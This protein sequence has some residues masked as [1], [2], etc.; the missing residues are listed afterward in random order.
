MK[1][2]AGRPKIIVDWKTVGKY[3]QAQC[4][5]TGIAGLLGISVDTLYKACK[6]DNKINFTVF[7]E[8]KKAEGKELLRVKQFQTAMTGNVPMCI[9]LGKQYLS[10]SDKQE[11]TGKDGKDLIPQPDLSKLTDDELRTL[12]ELQ[13]K[14]GVSKA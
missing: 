7:S 8:E 1:S 3:L 9:W 14:S 13:S 5:A 12:V 11:V 10:Q 4:K 6:R 2:K